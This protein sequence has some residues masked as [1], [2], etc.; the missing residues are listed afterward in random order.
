MILDDLDV[1]LAVG[2]LRLDP[3]PLPPIEA[4]SVE[5]RALHRYVV[6][7]AFNRDVL[8]S[9]HGGVKNVTLASRRTG[10]GHGMR[11]LSAIVLASLADA[12]STH[13]ESDMFLRS[14]DDRVTQRG[15]PLAVRST[16]RPI[17]DPGER[18]EAVQAICS[19]F[20]RIVLPELLQ[21]GIVVSR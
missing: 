10:M 11:V 15:L 7:D 4:P 12:A 21:L 16:G 13:V 8:S 17:T 6:P 2:V 14:V 9:L 19:D 1:A 5:A 20:M 3:Q 18:Y